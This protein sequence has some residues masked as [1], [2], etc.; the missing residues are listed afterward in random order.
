MQLKWIGCMMLLSVAVGYCVFGVRRMQLTQ[1]QLVCWVALLTYI[2]GQISCYSMPLAEILARAP[3]EMI[4]PIKP[5]GQTDVDFVTLC[6]AGA[7]TLPKECGRLLREL[8]DEIGTIWR[9]E[10]LERLNVY[11]VALEKEKD[12]FSAALPGR[13]RLRSTLSLCSALALIILMW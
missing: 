12:T 11:V 4:E 8:S 10:Q 7:S 13:V 5:T 2:R 6:R 1:R 3:R 9:Q